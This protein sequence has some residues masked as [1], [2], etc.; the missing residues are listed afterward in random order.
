[1]YIY[2]YVKIM[3]NTN[4][5][6]ASHYPKEWINK[7]LQISDIETNRL[8]YWFV[9]YQA[10]FK[11]IKYFIA[12]F[13]KYFRKIYRWFLKNQPTLSTSYDYKLWPTKQTSLKWEEMPNRPAHQKMRARNWTRFPLLS[14]S[15]ILKKLPSN[16]HKYLDLNLIPTH[17]TYL[18]T[19]ITF[20]CVIIHPFNFTF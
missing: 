7:W 20:S 16:L 18:N 2:I 4:I 3:E 12:I 17:G 10:I 19:Y 11:K 8:R 13:I 1:M 9:I 15:N 14:S 5:A 6:Y